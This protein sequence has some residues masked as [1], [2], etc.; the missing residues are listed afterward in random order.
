M[1]ILG[2]HRQYY[3]IS[4]TQ[5]YTRFQI[6]SFKPTATGI[7]ALGNAVTIAQVLPS[8][9]QAVVYNANSTTQFTPTARITVASTLA[10]QR[11]PQPKSVVSTTI[12]VSQY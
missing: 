11:P 10:N 2:V 6:H 8:R 9:T 3:F 4:F 1:V 7:Q 12:V 5:N